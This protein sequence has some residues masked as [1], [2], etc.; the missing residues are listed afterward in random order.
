MVRDH[1]FRNEGLPK[2]LDAELI[3]MVPR[4]LREQVTSA[5]GEL[6]ADLQQ[7]ALNLAAEGGAG[8][9]A[10]AGGGITEAQLERLIAAILGRVNMQQV[11]VPYTTAAV[12]L[13]PAATRSYFL[14][15]NLDAAANLFVGVNFQPSGPAARGIKLIAGAAAW[16]P[17]KVPQG[18]IWI[19]GDAAG[20][21]TFIVANG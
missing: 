1:E 12:L 8:G 20:T 16:E 21:A 17:I 19:S 6:P 13:L 11:V 18:D 7:V 9:A 14:V 2:K 15:Q 3:A 4:A 10:G 5:Y